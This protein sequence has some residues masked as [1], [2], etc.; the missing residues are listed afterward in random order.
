[1]FDPGRRDAVRRGLR[2]RA[3]AAA[4]G[5]GA[6]DGRAR[7][8]ID[9]MKGDDRLLPRLSPSRYEVARSKG[10]PMPAELF[11]GFGVSSNGMPGLGLVPTL[12]AGL[13]KEVGSRSV[14]L[15]LHI[16]Y[17][18]KDATDASTP[19]PFNYGYSRIG[20]GGALL[21]PV[22]GGKY[23]V[24]AGVDAS[25]GWN[26]QSLRDGRHFNVGDVTGGLAVVA[27]APVGRMRLAF[28]GTFGGTVL[29]LNNA[30]TVKPSAVASIVLLYGF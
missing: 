17:S 19:A 26:S 7:A 11:A 5:H 4:L 2:R 3:A 27:S 23:L 12:R 20:G 22:Y 14:A 29:K 9:L 8:E 24:E 18:A 13:R 25:Y 15:R 1:V 16:D 6:R 30:T 28:D 10:G 21:T